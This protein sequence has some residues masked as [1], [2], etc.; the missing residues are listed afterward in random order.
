MSSRVAYHALHEG[1]FASKYVVQDFSMPL[2]MCQAFVDFIQS[3]LPDY[4]FYICPAKNAVD[5]K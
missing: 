1:G 3:V 5:L 4:Q 2:S